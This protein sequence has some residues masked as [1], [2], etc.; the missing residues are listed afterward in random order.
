[1]RTMTPAVAAADPRDPGA[2]TLVRVYTFSEIKR[3]ER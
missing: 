3:R 2:V 1:M